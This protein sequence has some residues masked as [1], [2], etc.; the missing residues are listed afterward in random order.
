MYVDPFA[1]IFQA[2]RREVFEVAVWRF[3]QFRQFWHFWDIPILDELGILEAFLD[4]VIV[5]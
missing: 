1:A 5:E 3:W 2:V 4:L